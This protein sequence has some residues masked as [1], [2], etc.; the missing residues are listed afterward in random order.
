MDDNKR[1]IF[2]KRGE[3]WEHMKAIMQ[4]SYAN[5]KI[6]D[7]ERIITNLKNTINS[8]ENEKARAS[9]LGRY[10]KL[11]GWHQEMIE[12][13][14]RGVVY[15]VRGERA[16]N[17][18]LEEWKVQFQPF[19]PSGPLNPFPISVNDPIYT[20]YD[21]EGKK[22]KMSEYK[23]GPAEL[24]DATI[25]KARTE[26]ASWTR[27]QHLAQ[28]K[29]H[30]G[31]AKHWFK[32]GVDSVAAHKQLLWAKFHRNEAHRKTTLLGH[33]GAAIGLNEEYE[34]EQ[35]KYL[36]NLQ[37]TVEQM[38]YE[39]M[40][41]PHD[42]QIHLIDDQG[43]HRKFTLTI[44]THADFSR[45]RVSFDSPLGKEFMDNKDKSQFTVHSKASGMNLTYKIKKY[46]VLSPKKR[47]DTIKH[48]EKYLEDTKHLYSKEKELNE[49]VEVLDNGMKIGNYNSFPEAERH[50]I[51][52][53]SKTFGKHATGGR[54]IHVKHDHGKGKV[55][56]HSYFA[57][58]PV[59]T[60][61]KVN[62]KVTG[63]G[64]MHRTLSM[65]LLGKHHGERYIAEN[66]EYGVKSLYEA[67]A[68]IYAKD[69]LGVDLNENYVHAENGD[70]YHIQKTG[71][72]QF[73]F[74]LKRN[75]VKEPMVRVYN[76]IHDAKNAMT[77]AMRNI[78]TKQNVTES[79]KDYHLGVFREHVLRY[80]RAVNSRDFFSAAQ[81][82]MNAI[83][84]WRAYIGGR[85]SNPPPEELQE[86]DL[87]TL[88]A[89]GLA[90][91]AGWI[92][93]AV[94][95]KLT[96]DAVFG[97]AEKKASQERA[98]THKEIEALRKDAEDAKN[99]ASI[100]A[101]RANSPTTT[102][103]TK[104]APAPVAPRGS[105][106]SPQN[107]RWKGNNFKDNHFG[108]PIYDHKWSTIHEEEDENRGKIL[109]MLLRKKGYGR[110]KADWALPPASDDDIRL[111]VPDN[112]I[113]FK[114]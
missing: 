64:K 90:T 51:D 75:G 29:E 91:A 23:S 10:G 72:K 74:T 15:D 77:M 73:T 38:K 114:K 92:G 108:D 35:Q 67:Y 18:K 28:A 41:Y 26:H 57:G 86:I 85:N 52:A 12:G 99:Y 21:S 17:K 106:V 19:T 37:K 53:S 88:G 55:S 84:Y 30:D 39:H 83:Q 112:K 113:P 68:D 54:T 96:K 14:K 27:K 110:D 103:V 63:Q 40:A 104:I 36:D 76:N 109:R 95:S 80:K 98:R 62:G 24:S 100:A 6:S 61:V 43:E 45:G 42:H 107:L 31:G 33:L 4:S 94:V 44:P 13:K 49:N 82:K 69:V 1:K 111:D 5:A 101:T 46:K 34:K 7:H 58:Q 59:A 3:N 66:T 78:N 9:L 22:N 8:G 87:M 93:N 47:E 56:I 50:A 11:I 48:Y 89:A 2:M 79:S 25:K 32:N 71:H 102:Y 81:H 60:V 20:L 105:Q 65:P 16:R 70:V 97:D